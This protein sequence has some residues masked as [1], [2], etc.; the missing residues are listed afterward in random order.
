[1]TNTLTIEILHR[2]PISIDHEL[3]WLQTHD[4]PTLPAT[5]AQH[6]IEQGY[7]ITTKPAID[8]GADPVSKESID[9]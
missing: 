4:R 5:I 7:A 8:Y 6:L 1:M 9:A 3:V 2:V